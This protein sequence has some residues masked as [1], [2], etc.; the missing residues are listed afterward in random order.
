MIYIKRTIR[1]WCTRF[2]AI[3]VNDML[4]LFKCVIKHVHECWTKASVIHELL[5]YWFQFSINV[6]LHENQLFNLII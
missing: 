4:C 3:N 1:I 6:Y 5:N 2:Y